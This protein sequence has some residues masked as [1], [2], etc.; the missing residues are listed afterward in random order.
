MYSILLMLLLV[1][2]QFQAIDSQV[3]AYFGVDGHASYKEVKIDSNVADI[4]K[5]SYVIYSNSSHVTIFNTTSS[6]KP[7]DYVAVVGQANTTYTNGFNEILNAFALGPMIII[8]LI[9]AV[10]IGALF[11]LRL[12]KRYY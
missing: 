8:V 6:V 4:N 3:P 9:V 1:G 12:R 2:T 11:T 5:V 7:S 10:I